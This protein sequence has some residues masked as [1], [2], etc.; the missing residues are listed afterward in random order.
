[1][2][3]ITL[4]AKLGRL[5][6]ANVPEIYVAQHSGMKNHD[7][8]SSYKKANQKSQVKM[9]DILNRREGKSTA[10]TATVAPANSDFE[11]LQL[12]D[13]NI[14]VDF[15]P[16]A[17]APVSYANP[18]NP[19]HNLLACFQGLFSNCQINNFHVHFDTK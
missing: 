4:S 5:L 13:W 10:N 15:F 1:M 17:S 9:S 18:G 3:R 8:L 16:T 19:R 2:F 12:E 6:D 11:N 14:D 7:S